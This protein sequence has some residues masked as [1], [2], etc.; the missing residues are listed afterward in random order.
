MKTLSLLLAVAISST[1]G[2]RLANPENPNNLIEKLHFNYYENEKENN[3]F[4]NYPIK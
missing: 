3:H 1:Q 4:E 2:I